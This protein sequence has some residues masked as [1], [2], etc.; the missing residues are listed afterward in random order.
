[1]QYIRNISIPWVSLWLALAAPAAM[2]QSVHISHC[3]QACPQSP[4]VD[5]IVV[6]HLYAAGIEGQTG[7]AEWVSYRVIRDSIGVASL[8][9]R[10][11]QSD[12]LLEVELAPELQE[13][14]GDDFFQPD[15]S[16]AQDSE[17][18]VNE[19]LYNVEDRGRLAP[20]TSFAG[21]P[22]WRE[23]NNLSNMAPLPRDL[24]LGSWARLEQAINGLAAQVG[25]VYVLAGPLQQAEQ[26]ISTPSAYYKVVLFDNRLASFIFRADLDQNDSYCSQVSS[27]ANI[28]EMTGLHLFPDLAGLQESEL[29]TELGCGQSE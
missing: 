8:L 12:R 14:S 16:N 18:R 2:A 28:E 13:T 7:M 24:R 11:W 21:T 23:L 22:Y 6:H 1:M 15:L 25:E 3:S 27:L 26:S 4:D 10:L 29:L 9:P 5:E 17:Y 20:M 19:I